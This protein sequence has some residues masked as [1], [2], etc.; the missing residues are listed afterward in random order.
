MKKALIIT[1]VSGFLFKF[2]RQNVK[3]LQEL[4]YEVHYAANASQ[5][6]YEFDSDEFERQGIFFHPVAI[7]KSPFS[8]AA[9]TRALRQLEAIIREE[10]ISLVHCH[11]PVGGLLGRLAAHRIKDRNIKVIYTAHGFHFYK[12]CSAKDYLIYHTVEKFLARYTDAIVL[13]NREDYDS[14][15]R[16][17]LKKGGKV[18]Q[19]PGVGLD[20]AFFAPMTQ[21]ERSRTRDSLG[22]SRDT[23]FFLSVGELN[24]NKNHTVILDMLCLMRE[25]GDDLSRFRFWICGNGP[26]HEKL[27]QEIS[28]RNL[29]QMVSLKGYVAAPADLYNAADLFFFPSVREGLGMAALEALSC[30]CPVIAADNRGSR[31][32][33]QPGK[34]GYVCRPSMPQ[35]YLAAYDAWRSLSGTDKQKMRAFCTESTE[36]FDRQYTAQIMQNVYRTAE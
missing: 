36:R 24:A 32:Y 16:F 15:C 10:Q 8:V 11:T 35:D 23:T 29:E 5:Q 18:Y 28:R 2:E 20:R 17:R 4:G 14:A 1:T 7:H 26:D 30:G 21:E 22:L 6:V 31:E 12:G 9:N 19:I 25:R 33:M 27:R 3:A 34:N 13:I